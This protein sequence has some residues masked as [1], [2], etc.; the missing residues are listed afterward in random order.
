MHCLTV[1]FLMQ[2]SSVFEDEGSHNVNIKLSGEK[3]RGRSESLANASPKATGSPD[4][5]KQQAEKKYISRFATNV[6]SPA[7]TR[8][9]MNIRRL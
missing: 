8:V 2:L 7:D 3:H 5:F 6:S 1:V 4:S 9:I